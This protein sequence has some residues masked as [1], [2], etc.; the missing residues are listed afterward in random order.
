MTTPI[1][2]QQSETVD[3]NLTFNS[4]AISSDEQLSQIIDSINLS[5]TCE[6]S[7]NDESQ[8]KSSSTTTTTTTTTTTRTPGQT[9]I[10]AKLVKKLETLAA[11]SKQT[12]DKPSS[13]STND[14]SLAAT[15]DSESRR[16]VTKLA[17]NIM[18]SLTDSDTDK[19]LLTLATKIAEL[20]EQQRTLQTKSNDLEKRTT[21]YARERDHI[22]LE[23][24]RIIAAKTKLESL[25]R[26]LHRHNQQIQSTQQ[27][28]EDEAKRRE[29]ATK[30]QTTIDEI[31]AQLNDY[32]E[33]SAA[34]REQN[35]QL[36]E[37]LPNV[38]KNY[39]LRQKELETS[40]KKR[41]LELRLTEATLEQSNTL[42]NERNELVKQ[43]RQVSEA[44]RLLLNK[45]CEELSASE[46]TLRSQ[47]QVYSDRYKEFQGAI[48]QSSQ[49]VS[50]C[51][52]EIE[53]M[54]KKIKKLEKER[55]DFRHRWEI[56]EQSQRKSSEDYQLLE[57]EK[58]QLDAK[59]EK[60]DKLSRALQQE[61][62]DLQTT[63]KNLSKSSNDNEQS[64]ADNNS[65]EQVSNGHHES[66]ND[67]VDEN[68]SSSEPANLYDSELGH[69]ANL[70]NS[71][72]MPHPKKKSTSRTPKV[73][74]D[75][76]SPMNNEEQNVLDQSTICAEWYRLWSSFG[77]TEHQWFSRATKVEEYTR[78]LLESKLLTYKE[79]LN[80]R[81]KLLKQS[82]E[83]Y[84]EL[85]SRTGLPSSIDTLAFDELKL[86]EQETYI[87]KKMQDLL[88]QEGQLIHQRSEFENQQKQLCK[89]L[90]SS[91]IEFD[92]SLCNDALVEINQKIEDH[93]RM[94]NDLKTLRLTQVSSYYQ[95]LKHYSE[96]LEWTP[97]P[98]S[99]VEYLLFEK[100]DL[101]LTADCLNEIESTIH[102]LENKIEEQKVRFRQLH[103]QLEHLYERLKKN[104]ETDYCLA[105]KTD[106]ENINAFTIKQLE[107]EIA[108][109]CEERMKHGKEYR[110]SIRQQIVDLLDK[111]HLGDDERSILNKLD[112]EN[113]SADLLDAYDAEYE[114]IAQLYE[115]RR[116]V[117]DAYD[118][119]VTFWNDFV[120]F[121]KASTDPGRFRIRG[122]NAEVE[123][124]KRKKFLRELPQIEQE[125]LNILSE[126]DDALFLID[127][128]PIRQK[129]DEAHHQV[130]AS[131]LP[132]SAKTVAVPHL[133][134]LTPVRS[135]TP[136]AT[137]RR[138]AN[139]E[140]IVP[141]TT[142]HRPV[143]TPSSTTTTTTTTG[144]KLLAK[145]ASKTECQP[146]RAKPRAAPI[147][148]ASPPHPV[149][150]LPVHPPTRT[151]DQVLDFS[152]LHTMKN[153]HGQIKVMTS[154]PNSSFDVIENRPVGNGKTAHNTIGKRK[155]KRL[156]APLI[157]IQRATEEIP[158]LLPHNS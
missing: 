134:A 131:A 103:N 54:G 51:H 121:T 68:T 27:Q 58:R 99:S 82:V 60:L 2:D 149:A 84:E 117:I 88:A 139:K 52:S 55:G 114:R 23:N 111:S 73:T 80:K 66:K 87:E 7:T 1:S 136:I 37:Q 115:K 5:T 154:T 75:L 9:A 92:E 74:F 95:K 40:L 15:N 14:T 107:H 11:T 70:L 48:Q 36:S 93:V 101:C 146:K 105:Y 18:K 124:R 41:E 140:F 153:V 63:I 151:D 96:Q 155:S 6:D 47:V 91:F 122:Y 128:T 116:P 3:E 79:Q 108:C 112:F 100:F 142:V 89:L 65:S 120:A 90:N 57:K 35:A 42:L 50:S 97:L 98:S 56:A 4:N 33:K 137:P 147:A 69:V 22:S 13:T 25:C 78:K 64:V 119:W 85:I 38:V 132:S 45:K 141:S 67:T 49:M 20:Q 43:E 133:S 125:F 61:R 135:R 26:E 16:N 150:P 109:C 28:R 77:F 157:M 76:P 21:T 72:K 32:S 29:L 145:V 158:V 130:P 19:N 143:K 94:L 8:N 123:G 156:A 106:G 86:R 62:V 126:H 39:E 24:S 102:D 110:Q 81:K 17:K 152:L 71:N 53:K 148:H 104:P 118:K 127:N 46:L 144:R 129:F 31:A 30:F 34:L 113:L 83:D 10:G 12:D 44:E 59:L 138:V